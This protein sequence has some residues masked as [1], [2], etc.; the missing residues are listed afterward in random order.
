MH[1]HTCEL[2]LAGR[3]LIWSWRHAARAQKRRRDLPPFVLRTLA[4]LPQGEC[5]SVRAE[6][7][8]AHWVMGTRRPLL[9]ACPDAGR[10]SGDEGNLIEAL[11]A[12]HFG[13]E[14]DVRLLLAEQQH[15]GGLRRTTRACL[16]LA[17]LLRDLA[18]PISD[19]TTAFVFE[20]SPGLIKTLHSEPTPRRV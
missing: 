8:F 5:I 15:G 13:F 12:A 2:S 14:D 20:T 19:R 4:Q 7:L 11:I 18:L 16:E 3:L 10:L 17:K 1:Q 6:S 9:L